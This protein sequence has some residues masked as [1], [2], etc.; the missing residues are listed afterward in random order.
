MLTAC[1]HDGTSV[2]RDVTINSC[3]AEIFS[4]FLPQIK[5]FNVKFDEKIAFGNKEK[6]R[7]KCC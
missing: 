2:A 5:H 3:T 7:K 6:Q 1:S 4:I